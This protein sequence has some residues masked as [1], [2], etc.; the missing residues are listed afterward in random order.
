MNLPIGADRK[1][2]YL[3]G[4]LVVVMLGVFYYNSSSSDSS[5]QPSRPGAS[6]RGP[7]GIKAPQDPMIGGPP[8][9]QVS[10]R[11]PNRRGTANLQE[12][13]PSLKP[14]KPE[15]RSDPMSV[16]P[17][18][19]LDVLK[20]LSLVNVESTHRSIFDFSQPPPPPPPTGGTRG[21]G[22]SLTD[23]LTRPQPPPPSGPAP[24]PPPPPPPPI[25]LK[26]YGYVSALMQGNKR[27]FFAEGDD[28]F[29][30]TEGELVKKRYRIVRIGVNSVVVEDMQFK[31]QQTLP[32]EAQPA[33]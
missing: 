18:I 17:T 15:E 6:G 4:G 21:P 23:V 9:Q 20:K 24:P 30:A 1:K 25:P 8:I 14:K 13:H 31:N 33:G 3:L 16:D 19:K 7:L 27:A 26:F 29:I 22:P 11:V 32:L 12:F 10:T 2:I 5:P 28:I